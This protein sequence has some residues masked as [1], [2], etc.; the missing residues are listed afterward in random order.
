VYNAHEDVV[1]LADTNGNSVASY[2][3][4]SWGNLTSSSESFSNGWSNPYRYDG[5][6]GARYDAA[7]G[8][9]WLSMRAY[10]PTL[11]R[12]LSR[13]PL[14]RAPLAFVDQPYVYAGNNP[15]SNVDPSGQRFFYKHAIPTRRLSPPPRP[16]GHGG[17]VWRWDDGNKKRSDRYSAWMG[18][19]EKDTRGWHFNLHLDRGVAELANY[20]VYYVGQSCIEDQNQD[21]WWMND[22]NGR[23]KG[24]TMFWGGEE[25]VGVASAAEMAATAAAGYITKSWGLPAAFFE[26]IMDMPVS[27]FDPEWVVDAV[28]ERH[29]PDMMAE[30]AKKPVTKDTNVS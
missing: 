11:G 17:S 8:L 30:L 21:M 13:D 15:V 18:P 9:Y 2:S 26:R 7:T 29:L 22:T 3:Y 6:D 24:E 20:H 14:N 4:D 23:R 19:I 27:F 25:I 16:D 1:N 28:S 10:D 5:R 12:F